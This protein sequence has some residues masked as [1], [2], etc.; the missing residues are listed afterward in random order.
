MARAKRVVRREWTKQDVR[1]LK[2][3]SKDKTPVKKSPRHSN[4]RPPLSGTKPFFWASPSA[5]SARGNMN[6]PISVFFAVIRRSRLAAGKAR[7][8]TSV[9]GRFN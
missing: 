9:P 8:V 3:H 5:I 2:K 4:A 7:H 1:V 6:L